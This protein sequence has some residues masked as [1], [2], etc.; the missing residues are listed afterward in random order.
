MISLNLARKLKAAGLVW[1][2]APNDFFAIP[3]RGMD[4]RLFVLSDMQAQLDIFRGWPVVT[5]HGT[6]EWALDYILTSEVV[7]MP[8]EE[9]LRD[10]LLFRMADENRDELNLSFKDNLYTCSIFWHETSIKE[11]ASSAAD[12]Y[13]KVLLQILENGRTT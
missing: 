7:W 2:A 6:A 11:T 9:Q 4:D 1:Q 13:G 12:A 10:A 3:D 8:R 5:F